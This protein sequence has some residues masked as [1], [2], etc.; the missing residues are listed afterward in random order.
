MLF[1]AEELKIN[2]RKIPVEVNVVLNITI[3]NF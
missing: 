3:Q 2:I 1:D